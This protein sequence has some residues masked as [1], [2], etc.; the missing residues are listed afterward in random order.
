MDKTQS[1]SRDGIHETPLSEYSQ[2]GISVDFSVGTKQKVCL[3][4]LK[5]F[6][7]ARKEITGQSIKPSD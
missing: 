5:A 1:T 2:E 3:A 6:E 4:F 7:E